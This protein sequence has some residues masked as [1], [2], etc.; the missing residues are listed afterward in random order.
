[1][2]VLPS[3]AT[4]A[5]LAT[6]LNRTF[7]P[8]QEAQVQ[9]LL[10]D[11]SST[12]RAFTRQDLTRATTTDT[13]TMRRA[14]PVLHQCAGIVTLPQRPV[15]DIDTVTIDGSTSS[16]WWQDGQDLLL[17]SWS[18]DQP[19]TV[20]R[21]PQVTVTYTHGWDPIPGEI[22]AIVLQAVNRVLVNPSQVRSETV[23]GESVTYLIPTTGEA[24]GVL[25][26]RT[27]EKV[28]KKYRGPGAASLQ[29]RSR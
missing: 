12:V 22:T 6:R 26:S 27:E 2:A 20:H 17:R 14:D 3:L 11:A 16:D 18:W 7:T 21:A 9:A 4:V 29:V 15:V 1:M 23:G 24:L 25:L 28:L 8:Q 5:D 19:P 10:D 13:F